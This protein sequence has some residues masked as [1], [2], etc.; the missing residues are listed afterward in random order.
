MD[1]EERVRMFEDSGVT[2]VK[3][4]HDSSRSSSPVFHAAHSILAGRFGLSLG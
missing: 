1:G 4:R 3:S 2:L